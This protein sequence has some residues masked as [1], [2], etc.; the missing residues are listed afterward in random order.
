[1]V[2]NAVS[3]Q[4]VSFFVDTSGS[5][6]ADKVFTVACIV[7]PDKNVPVLGAKLSVVREVHDC[8]SPIH[9]CDLR[10]NGG[11]RGRVASDWMKLFAQQRSRIAFANVFI[12]PTEHFD[13]THYGGD[14]SAAI[15][16]VICMNVRSCLSRLKDAFP[17][18]KA[19]VYVDGPAEGFDPRS[20]LLQYLPQSIG[21]VFRRSSFAQPEVE[22][23][24]V[25]P[26]PKSG[27]SQY[28]AEDSITAWSRDILALTDVFAGASRRAWRL[29]GRCKERASSRTEWD[30]NQVES[31]S[32][33][34]NSLQG[35]QAALPIP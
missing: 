4:P 20:G 14:E 22:S 25:K 7:M 13:L 26:V 23:V 1:M 21:G 19:T 31:H 2:A 16:R 18:V 11:R 34:A 27:A 6:T 17:R 35:S 30:F 5:P 10:G 8:N 32:T 33:T 24:C 29:Q 9:Y 28:Q 3:L 12:F 15:N